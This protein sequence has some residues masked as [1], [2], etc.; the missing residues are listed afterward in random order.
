[1]LSGG[2]GD[3]TIFAGTGDDID[4]GDGTDRLA[5]SLI[6]E[7][8]GLTLDLDALVGGGTVSFGS[9]TITG[10]ERLAAL[11][12][13]AFDDEIRYL[14]A[15]DRTILSIDA[16]D[17]NDHIVLGGTGAGSAYGDVFGGAGD[18]V[19]DVRRG[20]TGWV[21]GGDGADHLNNAYNGDGG[22]GDD[23]LTNVSTG[24]GGDGN[25]IMTTTLSYANFTGGA[26]N[27]TLTGGKGSDT[28]YGGDGADIIVGGAGGDKLWSGG[29]GFF[30]FDTGAEVDRID[31]GAG[32]DNVLIGFGDSADG[33]TGRDL[34]T[35]R[36]D[37]ATAG[38]TLDTTAFYNGG[39]VKLGGGTI[40]GFEYF[41]RLEGSSFDDRIT[42]YGG[43]VNGGDGDDRL[44]ASGT[45]ADLYGGAGDDVV[46][47]NARGGSYDGSYGYDTVSFE[48]LRAR[49]TLTL[50]YS[51]SGFVSTGE[52]IENF[53]MIVATAFADV[54]DL[55]YS[56]VSLIAGAGN[57]RI[58][59][60]LWGGE[61]YGGAGDDTL[62]LGNSGSSDITALV[63]GGEGADRLIIPGAADISRT[64]LDGTIEWISVTEEPGSLTMAGAQTRGVTRIDAASITLAT[65]GIADFSAVTLNASRLD[66]AAAGSR[67]TIGAASTL[68][69]I[70]GHAGADTIIS[71]SATR[72]TV[73]GGEGNDIVNFSA[74]TD[75]TAAMMLRGGAGDDRL[76]GGAGADT[77]TG[78]AG[79]DFLQGGLGDDRYLAVEAGEV[80]IEAAN[81]G[82]D[83]VE[84]S[85]S[86][87]LAA[88]VENLVLLDDAA[89][90]TG[91]AAANTITGNAYNNILNG[92]AG[93]DVMIGGD[94]NDTYY[95]DNIGDQVIE[96]EAH[97][98]LWTDTVLT[99]VS[100]TLP[101]GVENLAMLAAGRVGIGNALANVILGSTG[102]DTLYGMDG[103]DDITSGGGC[104]SH[105]RRQRRR[106]LSRRRR[107][108]RDRRGG[109]RWCRSGDRE[110]RITRCRRTSRRS[111]L[112]ARPGSAPATMA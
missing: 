16:A 86:F 20:Y 81:G 94:G 3:D 83:T 79:K 72:C 80:I 99:T 10:I 107:G 67:V 84:T 35:L 49:I 46:I 6:R 77:L 71:S 28:I 5:L 8:A 44:I 97:P 90:G 13:T 112:T 38:V 24:Y 63:S 59:F 56:S 51:G 103:D 14:A 21:Y 42:A 92:K 32:D 96:D 75:P 106:H 47:A 104:R 17:G 43:V 93:A 110:A 37:G 60:G 48:Q 66:C 41:D 29:D 87:T 89:N 7:A 23:V 4:G 88:N 11:Q 18:D 102:A 58:T 27:D 50:E 78:G 39:T 74:V 108:R 76:I 45:E 85:A 34:L 19:I 30:V 95:V 57:D 22:A 105:D 55:N 25:D 98:Y 100:F 1:M 82:T 36:L 111:S 73:D 64:R 61:I 52:H 40:T 15:V 69:T 109:E 31:A 12:A 33:G 54:I 70:Y 53:D 91:N 65:A 68:T 2:A 101:N 9:T 62:V 26:G